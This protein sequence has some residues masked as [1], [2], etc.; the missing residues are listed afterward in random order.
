MEIEKKKQAKELFLQTGLNKT[1]IANTLGISRKCL[2]SWI[3]EDGWDR[4]KHATENLP[5][6]L[7]ENCYYLF[8]NLTRQYLSE[9]RTHQPLTTQESEILYK[10][11]MTIN[12]LKK[13][14]TLNESME[15]FA[16]FMDRVQHRNPKLA[17][18]MAPIIDEFISSRAAI[19]VTYP[20]N[21]TDNGMIEEKQRDYTE[22][23]LDLD[24][25]DQMKQDAN[26]P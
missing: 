2:Y 8:G 23:R 19:S 3:R 16:F 22:F 11:A 20:D 18:E 26:S 7:V 6:M 17:K 24:A 14:T 13:Q 9:F 5:S 21:F 15:M 10:L 1:Q 25:I 4:L 12:K